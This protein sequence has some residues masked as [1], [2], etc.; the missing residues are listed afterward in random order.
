MIANRR[1]SKKQ[2]RQALQNKM[3]VAGLSSIVWLARKAKH[4]FAHFFQL[5]PVYAEVSNQSTLLDKWNS[6]ATNSATERI[7]RPKTMKMPAFQ[8]EWSVFVM[9]AINTDKADQNS[10]KAAGISSLGIFRRLSRIST[11]NVRLTPKTEYNQSACTP[12]VWS[13]EEKLI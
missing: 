2:V 5:H 12:V 1:R 4:I 11:T 10:A 6:V 13:N 9:S 7:E 8:V 3:A